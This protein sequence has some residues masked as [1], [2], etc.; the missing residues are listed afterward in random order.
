M[1]W[2][3]QTVYQLSFYLHTPNPGSQNNLAFVDS[4]KKFLECF[5][6][7]N[8]KSSVESKPSF[9]NFVWL[10]KNCETIANVLFQLLNLPYTG[11]VSIV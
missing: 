5:M 2:V 11:Q 6:L 3:E 7:S 10:L 9:E 8:Y 1:G 4:V